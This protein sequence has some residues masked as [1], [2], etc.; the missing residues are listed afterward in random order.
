CK[1]GLGRTGTL[2]GAYLVWKYGFTANEAIA[3]MR[4]VRPGSVVGPQQQYLYLKQL[5][6]S[7]WAAI[8]EARKQQAALAAAANS[9]PALVTPATPPADTDEEMPLPTTP[10]TS[11]NST[12]IPLPP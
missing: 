8:D 2:I 12:N 1:A 10:T 9:A 5:E 11:R 6:W 7:K 3:F 4:I